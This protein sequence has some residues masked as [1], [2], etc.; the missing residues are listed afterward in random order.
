[1]ANE[2]FTRFTGE[3]A[4][5]PLPEHERPTASTEDDDEYY[6]A[7]SPLESIPRRDAEEE[8]GTSS[9]AYRRMYRE[10]TSEDSDR[11][12]TILFSLISLL[13][14]IA[15]L[16]GGAFGF[17]G[18]ILGALAI[19]FAIISRI[20]LGY[21]DPKSVIALILGIVGAIFGLFIGIIN[22][23]SIFEGIGNIFGNLF[24]SN[25]DINVQA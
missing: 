15:S 22:L 4:P 17:V 16:I 19:L 3:G 7:G 11:P 10:D 12:K 14:A 13:L 8:E 20:H 21:F 2:D 24:E 9:R 23:P 18:A 1:M 5:L 25:N 6:V